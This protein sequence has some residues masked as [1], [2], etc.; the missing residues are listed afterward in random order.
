[1]RADVI[2]L[3]GSLDAHN[4]TGVSI[5]SAIDFLVEAFSLEMPQFGR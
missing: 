1:M 2:Y 4:Q 5:G 3:A